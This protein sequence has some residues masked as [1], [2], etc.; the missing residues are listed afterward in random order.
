MPAREKKTL[1]KQKRKTNV[2]I[3]SKAAVERKLKN[4]LELRN[5]D[6]LM[7]LEELEKETQANEKK[8]KEFE[9]TTKGHVTDKEMIAR[10]DEADFFKSF[11]SMID[12]H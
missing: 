1:P 3:Q 10:D 7:Q 4:G 11:E 2:S 12:H 8:L 6:T 9:E 5:E